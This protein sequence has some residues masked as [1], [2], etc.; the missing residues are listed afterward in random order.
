MIEQLHFT[1]SETGLQ[2]RGRFQV[3]AASPGLQ[4][5]SGDLARLALRLCR[6][7][8]AG[9][10]DA[11]SLGWI[12]ARAHRFVFRRV[13]TGQTADGRPGSFAAHVLVAPAG[14]IAASDLLQRPSAAGLWWSGEAEAG[15][16]LPCIQPEDVGIAEQSRPAP[17]T[18]QVAEAAAQLL[19][20]NASGEV[21]ADWH[22][23]LAAAAH[24]SAVMTATFAS[25][26]SFS[27]Y[28]HGEPVGWFQLVGVGARERPRRQDLAPALRAANLIVSASDADRRAVRA[29]VCAT[30]RG[31][32]LHC[33]EFV[34]LAA[35][36][37]RVR[38]GEAVDRDAL[39]PA[40]ADPL[41]AAE[42]LRM[43]PAR[44]QIADALTS[45]D[46]SVRTALA[47][48][49]GDVDPNL[50]RQL[51]IDM[52]ER[53]QG[54]ATVVGVGQQL[55]RD[56]MDGIAQS[57]LR[58][59]PEGGSGWPGALLHACLRSAAVTPALVPVLARAVAIS[60]SWPSVLADR[61]VPVAYRASVASAALGAGQVSAAS[62]ASFAA[63]DW[64]LL[65]AALPVLQPSAVALD[66]LDALRP[67]DAANA[68][69]VV[70]VS[71]PEP[72]VLSACRRLVTALTPA[73]AAKLVGD[74]RGRKWAE[75]EGDWDDLATSVLR[76]AVKA[77]ALDT[78][79]ALSPGQLTSACSAGVQGRAW[80]ALLDALSASQV[81]PQRSHLG[82]AAALAG[83][84]PLGD[85]A[86]ARDYVLQV[87]V[88]LLPR[89]SLAASLTSLLGPLSARDLAAV[90]SAGE[91]A[92]RIGATGLLLEVID[93]IVRAGPADSAVLDRCGRLG[94]WVDHD[95]WQ[96]LDEQL[97]DSP[98]GARRR[99][100]AIYRRSRS[101]AARIG[102]LRRSAVPGGSLAAGNHAPG[103]GC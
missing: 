22:A 73:R 101:P 8:T 16:E 70:A 28:E 72:I 92:A 44:A 78:S 93:L 63:T 18:D 97:N 77:Q 48:A 74:L 30:E 61:D 1:W 29:A 55:G 5:L 71:L 85:D 69:A 13:P 37:A 94:R 103:D 88:P 15:R 89:G 6:W 49:V 40:L 4:D 43:R 33:R 21:A 45:G 99:L 59:H 10:Q 42:V 35:V 9:G 32:R 98:G 58:S 52:G 7:S 39:L 96:Y 81:A 64:D 53:M 90:A 67:Q 20:Q 95:G 87:V 26:T 46:S 31:G 36:L 82:R 47:A 51:G 27:T 17:P 65:L 34:I 84:G 38:V 24:C 66:V 68:L 11:V 3:T 60:D 83:S 12:D 91:R 76:L 100:R 50:L 102:G 25:L 79:T 75:R 23:V 56:V 14:L 80:R 19:A 57:A 41:T 62:L 2:G 54:V 86:D